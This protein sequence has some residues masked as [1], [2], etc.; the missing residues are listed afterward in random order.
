MQYRQLMA[1]CMAFWKERTGEDN[2]NFP[3]ARK[4]QIQHHLKYFH[5]QLTLA[6][7]NPA[8]LAASSQPQ[9][10]A[11]PPQVQTALNANNLQR[12]NEQVNEQHRLAQKAGKQSPDGSPPVLVKPSITVED[13]KIPA[14]RLK[15]KATE[16]TVATDVSPV[17]KSPKLAN[18][19]TA[20]NKISPSPTTVHAKVEE[21]SYPCNACGAKFK[22][23][24][25]LAPH[26]A[27]H[28]QE[29]EFRAAQREKAQENPV[30]YFLGSAAAALGCEPPKED[31][32]SS[33]GATFQATKLPTPDD[34]APPAGNAAQTILKVKTIISNLEINT[35]QKMPYEMF[36]PDA[37]PTPDVTPVQQN[38]Q[39][40]N[41]TCAW[42]PWNIELPEFAD[43]INW[44][45]D[46]DMGENVNNKETI[47]AKNKGSPTKECAKVDGSAW[48]EQIG[49]A[50]YTSVA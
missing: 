44:D 42:T 38:A 34:E 11:V 46:E 31:A 49:A 10:P 37:P 40:S 24:S 9:T 30:G 19:T 20:A 1:E 29:E 8:L 4:K 41:N 47:V 50:F 15:R 18:N 48:G 35:M 2:P 36:L 16:P 33:T 43:V 3:E 23:E 39:L 17:K 12:H 14:N 45:G 22:T 27:K 28:K 6:R 32:S 13:L 5:D 26:L 7:R 21:P 25:D